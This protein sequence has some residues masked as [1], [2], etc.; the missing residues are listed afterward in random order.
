MH[1]HI[2][3]SKFVNIDDWTEDFDYPHD[4]DNFVTNWKKFRG[5]SKE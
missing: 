3:G 5:E 4:Y 1:E 2:V